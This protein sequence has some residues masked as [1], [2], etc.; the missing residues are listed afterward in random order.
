MKQ[1]CTLLLF[2]LVLFACQKNDFQVVRE[3]DADFRDRLSDFQEKQAVET[4]LNLKPAS[5]VSAIPA[6]LKAVGMRDPVFSDE[7]VVL[8]RVLF[9]DKN[10]SRDRTISCASCHKQARAFSDNVAF[11]TGI[12]GQLSQRN[13]MP[14]GNVSSFAA[15]YSAIGGQ[16]PT[17]L[18]DHRAADVATQASLAFS[19]T[20]EMDLSMEEVSR[21]VT[22]QPYYAYLWKQAYGEFNVTEA[23]ILECISEFVGAIRSNNSRF[24]QALIQSSGNLN[25]TDTM[26]FNIY[27]GDTIGT[28]L[29][30]LP[31][32]SQQEF[33]G[34]RL[35]VDNCS[36][37]HSPIRPFQEVFMACNGLAKQYIDKGLGAITGEST[38]EGVFKSPPLRNIALTAPYMHDG[39]FKTLTEVVEF[40]NSQVQ[41]HPNLHPF[42][43]D[44]TGDVKRLHLSDGQKKELVAF[45]HTLTDT[46]STTDVRFSNPF[47]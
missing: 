16:G 42:L 41:N 17:L 18:W 13:A 4:Y 23:K 33:R 45:L 3:E 38:D 30:S 10:L 28:T 6:Y 22:E 34:L 9:Y 36:K 24:D 25:L 26:V 2:A 31:P 29:P 35:F 40:Y 14:L 37:C 20:R 43:R 21:R 39:R 47:K 7:K 19:N 32:L 8:G 5:Y 15:H 1:I 11:S 44:E 12:G 46:Y 27:Y